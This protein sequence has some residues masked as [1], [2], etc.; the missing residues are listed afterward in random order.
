MLDG[1]T[2]STLA[3]Y[4]GHPAVRLTSNI[5]DKMPVSLCSVGKALLAQLH[6]HDIESMF[7]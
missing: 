1:T 4:E 7:A 5:G 3:R 2:S 6:D